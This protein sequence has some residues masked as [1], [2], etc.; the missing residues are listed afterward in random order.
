MYKVYSSRAVTK[1]FSLFVK[2]RKPESTNSLARWMKSVLSN[3]GI[4]TSVFKAHNVR[5]ASVTNANKGVV[6]VAEILRTADW[7]NKRVRRVSII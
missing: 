2:R 5:G 3:A 4:D 1:L 7:T 6:P